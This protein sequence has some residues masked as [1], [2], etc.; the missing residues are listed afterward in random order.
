MDTIKTRV[1]SE[2]RIRN[3][4]TT[5]EQNVQPRK[6]YLQ[7]SVKVGRINSFDLMRIRSNLISNIPTNNLGD[8]I[9]IR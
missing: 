3:L 8:A 1:K 4:L 5:P 7:N 9:G 2:N 6:Q